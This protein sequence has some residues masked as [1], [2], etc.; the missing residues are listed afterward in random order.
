[1][2]TWGLGFPQEMADSEK[3]VTGGLDLKC[4]NWLAAG[5]RLR[6]TERRWRALDRGSGSVSELRA[7]PATSVGE[8]E[9]RSVAGWRMGA[10]K[11]LGQGSTAF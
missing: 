3:L 7:A 2:R 10:Q 9:G 4:R 8:S 5:V 11:G 1:M 6:Q